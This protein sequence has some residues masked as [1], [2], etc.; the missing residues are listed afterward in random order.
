[1]AVRRGVQSA[2]F[3]LGRVTE[4]VQSDNLSAATH[5]LGSGKRAFNREYEQFVLHLGMKPRKIGV[6]KSNQNGDVESSNNVLKRRLEQH[7]ILRGSRDFE[8]VNAYETWVQAVMSKTNELRIQ[9]VT[10]ELAT[11]NELSA[12]RL[13]EC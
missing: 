8:S 11:M 3:R 1:M 5:D 12:K 4:Y 10:E 6:G 2:V 9:K 13:C 7:L